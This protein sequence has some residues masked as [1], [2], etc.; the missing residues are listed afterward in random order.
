MAGASRGPVQE[1]ASLVY[2]SAIDILKF[3]SISNKKPNIFIVSQTLQ[4][5]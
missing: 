5:M 2:C 3:L 4:V 1:A